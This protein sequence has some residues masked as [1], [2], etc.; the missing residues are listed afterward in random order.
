MG[1]AA[2]PMLLT[3]GAMAVIAP[4]VSS[5]WGVPVIGLA[6]VLAGLIEMAQARE[7][8]GQRAVLGSGVFSIVAG[9]VVSFQST[10]V[11][12][13]LVAA[14]G[15][16]LGID[17][18]LK[19]GRALGDR[20]A[21]SRGWDL[22][23][24]F[25]NVGL[26]L[27]V[28]SARDSVGALGFGLLLGVRLAA[29]GWQLVFA[30]APSTADEFEDIE[31]GHPDRLMGLEPH[32]LI[33]VVHRLALSQA[34]AREP[35]DVYWSA[36]F[37]LTFF[38]IHVGRLGAEWTWLGMLSP[39]VATAGDVV[40]SLLLALVVLWPLES[41]WR[42][43]TRPFE[44][45]VWRRMIADR[46][47]ESSHPLGERAARWWAE[48]RL[49][50]CVKRDL[51]NNTLWGAVRQAIRAGLPITAVL[52][53]VNPIWGFSW[54][55]NSENW[56]TAVWQK[57]TETRTDT[58]RA[59]MIDAVAQG[60]GPAAPGLFAITPPGVGPEGDFSFLVIGDPGE[61]DA[62]QHA[63]RD[64]V[65]LAARREEVKF[66]V[67]SS[68]VVYPSGE[69]HD[70]ESNFYLP[71][72]GV[73]K[74]VYAIPGNHD[75]FSA[76]DGFAAHLMTPDAARAAVRARVQ[77]DLRMSS[78]TPARI[79]ANLAEAARLRELYRLPTALQAAPFF[80]LHAGGFSLVAV[81]T[82]ILR[83]VDDRQLAW[84]RA[85][86]ARSRGSLTMAILGHPLYA[87]GAYQ[88]AGD[89]RFRALHDLLREHGVKVVMGGDT[90]DFEYYREPGG[91]EGGTHHFV[92]GG[93]GA[94]LSIGTALNWPAVPPVPDYA[95]Y[96]RTDDVLAKLAVETPSWKRPAWWW[97][98]RVGAWPFSVERL[99]AVFDFNHAPFFQSFME[100]RVERSTGQLRLW[101]YGVDGRLPWR[102]I[103]V[104]GATQPANA[105]DTDLVEW[106]VNLPE[107]P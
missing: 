62:S 69:M 6:L 42:R 13:G 17:G 12:S 60:A 14:I 86:L 99:S 67:I 19:I 59:A 89:E 11:F 82:G 107:P 79:E 3:L 93:G 88:A 28:W 44:R 16:V 103:Q 8:G 26:A 37:I 72:K 39:A 63:L 81:D 10:L 48:H 92:N 80:E 94:Y 58:W 68:D 22:L 43:V 47:P 40:A 54:Y 45:V 32:P 70:Y 5:S 21:A 46:S 52:I 74:P 49:R 96:P 55:F 57:I 77:A 97:V 65:L 100:V 98:R 105:T 66:I 75:W 20:S 9:V 7:A 18:L 41:L 64:Q 76:L 2:G 23:N 4:L 30:P 33:G 87:A 95:F 78:T 90:H 102:A 31:D 35:I 29:S 50:R 104:G 1:R 71:L 25:T 73:E 15:L 53:A 27:A 85:A 51:E 34:R 84:L 38:A 91:A 106:T 36:T 83:S 24:G 101:L 61:G 56:A